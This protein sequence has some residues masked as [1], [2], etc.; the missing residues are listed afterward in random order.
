MISFFTEETYLFEI[1]V[2]INFWS[3]TW[4]WKCVVYICF[5]WQ[6]IVLATLFKVG[7]VCKR[8]I[9][10]LVPSDFVFYML[11]KYF[12][13]KAYNIFVAMYSFYSSANFYN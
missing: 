13:V 7:F 2:N 9:A 8:A 12:I 3:C 1:Y 11:K 5:V 6:L 10:I 4:W